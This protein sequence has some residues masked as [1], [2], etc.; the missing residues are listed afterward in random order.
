MELAAAYVDWLETRTGASFA[1]AARLREAS[2]GAK[3]LQFGLARIAAGRR[4]DLESV[5][6]A[7]AAC[8]EEAMGRLAERLG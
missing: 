3:T 5:L 1:A 8:W 7:T 2:E 4:F 6:E